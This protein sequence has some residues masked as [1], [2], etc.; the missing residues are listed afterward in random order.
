[1]FVFSL[2]VQLPVALAGRSGFS[3]LERQ[4]QRDV[5]VIL[6]VIPFAKETLCFVTAAEK[7]GDLL[8][9]FLNMHNTNLERL[10]LIESESVLDV[11]WRSAQ[12]F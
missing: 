8:E 4:V 6:N 3:V 5:H 7:D 9:R 2:P 12:C 11:S 10:C 1:M